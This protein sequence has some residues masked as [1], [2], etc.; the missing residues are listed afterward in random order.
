MTPEEKARTEQA[1][2]DAQRSDEI[3][4]AQENEQKWKRQRELDGHDRLIARG[5]AMAARDV[6]GDG[7]PGKEPGAYTVHEA[8]DRAA[9]TPPA[10]TREPEK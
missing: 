9:H 2:A 4:G 7:G 6:L 10:S 5:A 3:S 8:R 1:M